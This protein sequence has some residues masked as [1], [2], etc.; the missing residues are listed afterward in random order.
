MHVMLFNLGYGALVFPIIAEILP[1]QNRT[2]YMAVVTTF[3]G[4]FGFANAKSFV[5][6]QMAF[7]PIITF[8]VY[9]L[10]NIGGTIYFALC[11]PKLP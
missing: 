8:L 3:G 9:A 1:F 6:L 10:I 11:V 2:K 5:D 4:L 7:G